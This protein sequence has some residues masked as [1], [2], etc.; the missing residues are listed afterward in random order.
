MPTNVVKTERDERLWAEA[1]AQA[2]SQGRAEDWAYVMGIFQRMR[3]RQ[4]G[5]KTASRRKLYDVDP[6]VRMRDELM[7]YPRFA[8]WDDE[9]GM[10]C[11]AFL[12]SASTEARVEL[13]ETAVKLST[14]DLGEAYAKLKR[15][16]ERLVTERADDIDEPD[17]YPTTD[18]VYPTNE[19]G[20]S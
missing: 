19:D 4:G 20:G 14:S 8:V 1:K 15:E 18:F 2:E 9:V 12:D 3:N 13:F 16:N 10:K 5:A 17:D 6:P 11:A 7:T